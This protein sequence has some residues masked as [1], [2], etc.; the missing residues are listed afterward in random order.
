MKNFGFDV[1]LRQVEKLVEVVNFAIDGKVSEAQLKWVVEG[2]EG[3]DRSYLNKIK[4]TNKQLPP[5]K[6][7]N[8]EPEFKRY[9]STQKPSKN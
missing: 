5:K 2:L 8:F 7:V 3:K 1:T 4:R 9:K 6:P